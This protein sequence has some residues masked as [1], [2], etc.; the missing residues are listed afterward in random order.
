MQRLFAQGQFKRINSGA[1]ALIELFPRVA[2]LVFPLAGPR[3][4]QLCPFLIYSPKT[5][6][7]CDCFCVAALLRGEKLHGLERDSLLSRQ[8]HPHQL[9]Q[10]PH[11]VF[12]R[13]SERPRQGS[14]G[15]LHNGQLTASAP[16]RFTKMP[17]HKTAVFNYFY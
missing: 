17:A 15:G 12:P 9:L 3:D 4:L 6:L 14:H 11:Q 13:D 8:R 10:R 16:S 2:S 1:A 5:L 7:F